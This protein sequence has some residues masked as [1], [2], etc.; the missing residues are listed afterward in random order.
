MIDGLFL[1]WAFCAN[2]QMSQLFP[3]LVEVVLGLL[4]LVVVALLVLAG[5]PGRDDDGLTD[6]GLE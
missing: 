1:S 6:K 3:P 2:E 4:L 5:G